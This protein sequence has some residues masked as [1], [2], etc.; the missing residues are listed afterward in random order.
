M[1]QCMV[2]TPTRIVFNEHITY[3]TIFYRV[4]DMSVNDHG[5]STF[6]E[7]WLF[8]QFQGG[9][10]HKNAPNFVNEPCHSDQSCALGRRFDCEATHFF[11]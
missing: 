11:V 3:L 4:I 1:L 6:M 5:W 7:M 2:H 8:H 9:I 10:Q